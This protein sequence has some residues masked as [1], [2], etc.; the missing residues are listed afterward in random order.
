MSLDDGFIDLNQVAVTKEDAVKKLF[1]DPSFLLHFFIP[2]QLVYNIP[3]FHIELVNLF[4]NTDKLGT[5]LA[6]PRGFA[7]TTIA[8]IMVVWYFL[9]TRYSFIVYVSNTTP[10]A[11]EAVNDIQ[12]YLS[13]ANFIAMFGEIEILRKDAQLGFLQFR[14]LG[15][16]KVC[17]I[18]AIGAGQQL[19]GLNIGNFRPQLAVVDDLED[20][21]NTSSEVLTTKL[22]QWFFG[23]FIKA[24]DKRTRKVIQIGNML[25]NDSILAMNCASKEWFS[26]IY[27]C[28][29]ADGTSL[30]EDLWPREELL[31][32]YQTYQE[33]KMAH[34]WMAEMMNTPIPTGNGLITIEEIPYSPKMIPGQAE[35]GFITI[36]P[37]ISTNTWADNTSIVVHAFDGNQW[38]IPDYFLGKLDTH[39][40]FDVMLH[41]CQ[42]WKFLIVGIEGGG[43]QGTLQHIFPVLLL[44]R[45]INNIN[46]VELKHRQQ[47]KTERIFGWASMLKAKQY[48]LPRGDFAI[49]NQLVRYDPLKKKNDDDLIDACAYGP[50]MIREHLPAIM[51]SY[52]PVP[53]MPAVIS[54]VQ[55]CG[56]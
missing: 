40:M 28:L 44:Q 54:E 51:A 55:L 50:Q 31:R 34:I 48:V 15:L 16:D 24:L 3:N 49:Q 25:S 45:G 12:G 9:F 36:D 37:A 1:H 7:K 19:R 13:C 11:K 14:I 41:F 22:K 52:S 43:F 10:M 47:A 26:R 27:G 23:T 33:N 21:D 6:V 17:T 53:N 8:K 39:Q 42:K 35:F 5:A 4:K 29:L 32:D 18:R 30:W 46:I 2:E 56:V 38:H 20:Y